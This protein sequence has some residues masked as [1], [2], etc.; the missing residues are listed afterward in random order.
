M[1]DFSGILGI[2]QAED[3]NIMKNKLIDRKNCE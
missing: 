1:V 3:Q 2:G